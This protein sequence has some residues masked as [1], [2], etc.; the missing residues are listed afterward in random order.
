MP[1]EFEQ[2]SYEVGHRKILNEID[3]HVPDGGALCL[4][5]PTGSGKSTLGLVSGQLLPV[6]A[7]KDDLGWFPGQSGYLKGN[8]TAKIF[9]VPTP[10][11]YIPS[12]PLDNLIFPAVHDELESICT[13][14]LEIR[15][16]LSAV[17]LK[18]HVL[19]QE[20]TQLSGGMLQRLA[21]A[22]VI[23]RRPK[24]VI[25][26]ETYEW[27]DNEGREVF[28]HVLKDVAHDAGVALAMQSTAAAEVPDFVPLGISE[29]RICEFAAATFSWNQ[30]RPRSP[31]G[32]LVLELQ[33]IAKEFRYGHRRISVLKNVSLKA[34]RGEWIGIFG[35]NG[36]GKSVLS[37][38][39]SGLELADSGKILIEKREAD[40]SA[41]RSATG[42][43]FQFP[44]MQLPL[45]RVI[46]TLSQ[47]LPGNLHSMVADD[48]HDVL[49]KTGLRSR[50]TSLTP[51]EQ[52]CVIL[53]I[54]SARKPRILIIDEPTWGADASEVVRLLQTVAGINP[55]VVIII[56][57]NL[58]LLQKICDRTYRL[59]D[60]VLFE[61]A[62]NSL[63]EA[64]A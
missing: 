6:E 23:L 59:E 55:S 24:F 26:D 13:N 50:I 9:R 19:R 47:V 17:G 45:R 42:Y 28:R 18:E 30:I 7:S 35:P 21:L 11:V 58:G 22:R 54:L 38:I 16:A 20:L 61:V 5:G 62:S 12:N 52:R 57:H 37:R 15:E 8:R 44:S 40:I 60:G 3:L 53:S 32:E 51:Y 34:S 1:I 41:R 64:Y 25:A 49:P 48:L 46:D 14:P 39:I 4:Y 10:A 33:G 36:A 29:G 63:G 2:L 27:L 31:L 56:S 43:L